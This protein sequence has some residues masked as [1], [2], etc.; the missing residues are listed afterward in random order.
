[1]IDYSQ[2]LTRFFPGEWS[3]NGD[4]YEGLIWLSNTEKPSKKQLD[5]LW[6][7]VLLQLKEEEKAK[8]NAKKSAEEKLAAL[9]LSVDDLKALG[10]G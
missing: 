10:L 9:G 7:E 2:I 8:E 4:S 5:D 3:L 1:M 6:P